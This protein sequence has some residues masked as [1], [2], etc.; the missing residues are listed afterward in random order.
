MHVGETYGKCAMEFS[1]HG[2][3]VKCIV[4][5]VRQMGVDGF[6]DILEEEIGELRAMGKRWLV[7]S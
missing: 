4:Q 3:K 2:Q 6:I 5:E 7:K 1:C